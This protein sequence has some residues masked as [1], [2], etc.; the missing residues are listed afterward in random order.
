MYWQIV[1]VVFL[2]VLVIL[3]IIRNSKLHTALFRTANELKKQDSHCI[4]LENEIHSKTIEIE[5]A[6]EYYKLLLSDQQ[7]AYE[8]ERD[9]LL[10][11]LENDNYIHIKENDIADIIAQTTWQELFFLDQIPQDV[12]DHKLIPWSERRKRYDKKTAI[13]S[14]MKHRIEDLL[15]DSY[16]YAY[17]TILFPELKEVFLGT[18]VRSAPS[19]Q[20]TTIAVRSKSLFEIVDLLQ[21]GKT[22]PISDYLK[23]KSRLELCNKQLDFYKKASSNLSAIPY[24]SAIMADYETLPL[25]KIAQSLE[26]GSSERRHEKTVRIREIRAEAQRMIERNNEAKYQLEYLLNLF[27]AL[28]DIIDSDYDELP[29]IEE[30]D[31]SEHDNTKDW[32]SPEEYQSLNARDRNQL[33]L[34]RYKKSMKKTKWQIGRDYEQFVGYWYSRQGYQVDYFGS[35]MGLED[36]GRDLIIKK[37]GEPTQIIQCKYWSAKKRIHEKHILQLYG[38]VASYIIEHNCPHDSVKGILITN[39]GLSP[40]AKKMARYLSIEYIEGFESGEYPCIKCNIGHDA[41]GNE[42]KIYHLPFDQQYD[43]T[44]INKPGEFFAMTVAEAE[45]A[46]FRRTYKWFGSD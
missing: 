18:K 38:S 6:I 24:M 21:S 19:E 12:T 10:A 16:R 41:D 15:I 36:L 9:K 11:R 34:D 27:P 5:E 1:I 32:L 14:E 35:Y 31:L 40:M 29:I 46:G 3:F 25:E 33:A 8:A 7:K 39:I 44:K 26:W 28:K 37:Q 42:T 2:V 4:D 22:M 20:P 17:L 45:N 23:T 30:I 43:N 13:I